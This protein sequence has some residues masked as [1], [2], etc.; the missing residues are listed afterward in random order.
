MILFNPL[1]SI[2]VFPNKHLDSVV[3]KCQTCSQR[4][5]CHIKQWPFIWKPSYKG[6]S[7]IVLSTEEYLK[8]QIS[9]LS[10]I[11]RK[12]FILIFLYSRVFCVITLDYCNSLHFGLQ[13]EQNAAAWLLTKKTR[14]YYSCLGFSQF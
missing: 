10:L 6:H 11:L 1:K 8:N 5:G 12:S 14:S 13:L 2:P 9:S 4:P 3:Y 7:V